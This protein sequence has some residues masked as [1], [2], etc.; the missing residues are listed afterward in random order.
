MKNL[1]ATGWIL[2]QTKELVNIKADIFLFEMSY[3]DY[4]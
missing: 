3:T 2:E 4:I 1:A